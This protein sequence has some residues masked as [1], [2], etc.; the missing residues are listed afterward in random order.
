MK[1]R[2]LLF[3]FYRENM[4]YSCFVLCLPLCVKVIQFMQLYQSFS[5][6]TFSEKMLANVGLASDFHAF[7]RQSF[8]R[9]FNS[10]TQQRIRTS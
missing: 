1:I 8:L 3:G 5:L 7:K 9:L 10:S 4:Y 2:T 6:N